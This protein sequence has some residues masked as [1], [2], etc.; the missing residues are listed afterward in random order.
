MLRAAIYHTPRNP[1]YVER[2][3]EYYED[4]ALA[5]AAGRIVAAG[6][7]QAVRRAYPDAPVNDCRP[8]V[9]LPGFVDA[10][11]H[12]PQA[13]L[14]GGFD[15]PLLDWL[16]MHALPEE[17]RM[18]DT[19]YAPQIAREFA[20]SL[21][22]HGT[23]TA[24]VFGSH[25]PEAT[26][27]FFDAGEAAGLRIASG[28]VLSDCNLPEPLLQSPDAAY[29]ASKDLI[30]RYH[31]RGLIRYAVTPRF[32]LSA[33]EALLDVCGALLREHPDC[34]FQTHLNENRSEIE[35]VRAAF[36]RA[37]GYLDVYDRAG[38][39]SS[40]GIFAH[41]VHPTEAELA[42]L[43]ETRASVAHCPSSNLALASGLFPMRR[44][45]DARVH[46]A[47]GTDVGAGLTFG[48]LHESLQTL[49][50]RLAP[51]KVQLD[52]AH[53]L[54]LATRAGAEA[55]GLDSEIGDFTPG[56]SADLV[57]MRP[58]A[59]LGALIAMGGAENILE[60]RVAGRIVFAEGARTR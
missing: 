37:S 60:V 23:T 48:V 30:A 34:L 58:A 55:L 19:D 35:A 9:I 39:V 7:Y 13:R 49:A 50:Q 10:H 2:A 25:F 6:D 29:T 5:I 26:A 17:E 51:E 24:L 54:Y 15:W 31:G 56:K 44:H 40:R 43:A 38:L 36:P 57:L 28:L 12:F 20:D 41:N 3:L 33:S 53:L 47:L 18:R 1:F 42:R 45:L 14:I 4:G 27:A 32:A 59:S 22:R 52:A 11:T 46:F 21:A 16:R 8:A